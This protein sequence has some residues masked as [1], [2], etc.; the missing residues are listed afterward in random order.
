MLKSVMAK[1][2]LVKLCGTCCEARGLKD[3][4]L[5]EGTELSSMAALAA[6]TAESDKTLVF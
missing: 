6:W 1:G 2:G 5:V 4:A 3:L